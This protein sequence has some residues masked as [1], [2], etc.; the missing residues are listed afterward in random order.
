MSIKV[1]DSELLES[2]VAKAKNSPRL[3]QNYNLHDSYDEPCQ[4]LL[5]A[6]EPD[7][8]LPPIDIWPILSPRVTLG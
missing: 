3:R 7:S 4:R 8:Y 5:N 2:L 1:I 6:I